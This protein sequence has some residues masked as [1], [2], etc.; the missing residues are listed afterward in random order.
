MTEVRVPKLG[1]SM[2]DGVITEWLVEDGAVVEE[3]TPL[4]TLGT[5]KVDTDIESPVAGTIRIIGT[6]GETYLIGDLIAEI[7]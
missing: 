6:E 3:G 7:S 4:Y 5:D 1:V 2:E